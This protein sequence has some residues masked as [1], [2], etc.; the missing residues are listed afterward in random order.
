[1]LH[2]A[3]E[4]II[5]AQAAWADPLG[6]LFVAIFGALYKP[7]P[8]IKD[9]LHGVWLGHPLHPAVTDIP[10]GAFLV[11]LVLDLAGIRDGATVAIGIGLLGMLV[12]ALAGY[13]DYIDLEGRPL[14]FG[15]VHSA[16][17][18]VVLLLYAVSFGMRVGWF[19]PSGTAAE[20]WLAIIAL[21]ILLASAYLGGSLVF[22]M[23][24]QVDRN[25]FRG[26]G[27]KWAPVEVDNVADN[28]PVKAKAGSQTLVLVRQGGK[29]HA[30]HDICAHQACSLAGKGK[31]VGDAIECQC[32]GSRYRLRDGVVV[33]GPAVFNQPHFEIRTVEGRMEA[34]R[35]DTA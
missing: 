2:R 28:V 9:L 11:A 15:T 14:R 17:M 16:L 30:L 10:I 7:V 13:A 18:V 35:T 24:S 29:V 33:R 21:A 22:N 32:H 4:R 25:A 19:G 31:V 23:G 3:I 20:V 12:A 6:K 27:T 34:R 8:L 5:D 26:G 1:V